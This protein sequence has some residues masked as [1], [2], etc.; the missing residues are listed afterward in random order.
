MERRKQIKRFTISKRNYRENPIHKPIYKAATA[1]TKAKKMGVE[2]RLHKQDIIQKLE[3]QK[4]KCFYC[5]TD[6]ANNYEIDHKIPFS[7][8]GANT[9]DNIVMCCKQ[10]NRSKW[11]FDDIKRTTAKRNIQQI[12]EQENDNNY[13]EK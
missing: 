5:G 7:R 6:I 13:M 11:I 8:K 2:G 10:C 9:K 3:Q 4:N 12:K 1:N